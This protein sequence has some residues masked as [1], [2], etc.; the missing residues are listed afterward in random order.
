MGE[1]RRRSEQRERESESVSEGALGGEREE[2]EQLIR[3]DGR[4]VR[5]RPSSGRQREAGGR[6]EHAVD[7]WGY[8]IAPLFR[9]AS[10]FQLF[11][12]SM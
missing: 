9:S 3:V 4:C 11:M 5:S 6:E 12:P 1:R 10:P 7:E 8:V 2:G